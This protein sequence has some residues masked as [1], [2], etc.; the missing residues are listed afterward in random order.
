MRPP[1]VESK[2]EKGGALAIGEWLAD[3]AQR[4]GVLHQV[5]IEHVLALLAREGL[6]HAQLWPGVAGAGGDDA[7]GVAVGAQH[8]AF[9]LGNQGHHRRGSTDTN[10]SNQFGLPKT[11]KPVAQA[12]TGRKATTANQSLVTVGCGL[13]HVQINEQHRKGG[14]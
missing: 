2:A 13:K 14:G 4:V 1:H 8:R 11:V 12:M 3:A 6:A 10:R 9:V 5:L 7:N